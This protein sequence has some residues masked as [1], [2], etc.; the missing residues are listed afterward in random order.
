MI[1][2]VKM[3][4]LVVNLLNK[5]LAKNPQYNYLRDDLK[6][7]AMLAV[8]KVSKR[9]DDSGLSYSHIKKAFTTCINSDMTIRIPQAVLE[10]RKAAGEDL[11]IMQREGSAEWEHTKEKDGLTDPRSM[12]DLWDELLG[13]CETEVDRSI[14][15]MRRDGYKDHEIGS[16]LCMDQSWI[17]KLRKKIEKRFYEK[18]ASA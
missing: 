2:P 10:R 18:R 9:S 4:G 7:E 15:E 11:G 8:V 12:V 6:A 1:D 5:F 13:A 3:E 17:V 16:L 14:I